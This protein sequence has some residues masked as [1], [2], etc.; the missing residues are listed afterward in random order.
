MLCNF[1]L[2]GSDLE[3]MKKS[4]MRQDHNLLIYQIPETYYS[5]SFNI[6]YISVYS[7]NTIVADVT[8]ELLHLPLL[9]LLTTILAIICCTSHVRQ[10]RIMQHTPS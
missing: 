3:I 9:N 5:S 10:L 8:R 6:D 7:S 2:G 1:R 4:V